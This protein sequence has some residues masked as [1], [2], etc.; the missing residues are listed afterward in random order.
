MAYP[1]PGDPYASQFP[2]PPY[3]Q[4]PYGQPAP[5]A[6]WGSRVGAYL[7]DS[8]CVAPFGILAAVF[9]SSVDPATGLPSFNA[10]YFLFLILGFVVAGYNRWFQAGRTG[11]SWGRKALNIRLLNE[12]TG[13]PIGAGGAFVRDLAHILDGLSC[14][15]GFLW[16]LWDDKKQ[17]FADKI[18][19]TLV[20]RS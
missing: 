2:P 6:G 5:Y 9:G 16:P 1:P 14:Y 19:N 10:S 15:I 13:G 8:L 12:A 17:T 20:V 3:G 11:Q 7:I 18:C 4:S